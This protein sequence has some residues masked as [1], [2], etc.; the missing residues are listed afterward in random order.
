LLRDFDQYTEH[1]VA[2]TSHRVKVFCSILVSVIFTLGA[3][4]VL[5]CVP[6]RCKQGFIKRCRLSWLTNSVF[7]YEPKCGRRG[8]TQ[9]MSTAVH[10]SPNKLRKCNSIFNLWL[11]RSTYHSKCTVCGLNFETFNLKAVQ[12]HT[13]QSNIPTSL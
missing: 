9:P 7:V 13:S 5:Y 4:G 11:Q 2:L 3:S 10:R 1:P 6:L 8:L 12:L